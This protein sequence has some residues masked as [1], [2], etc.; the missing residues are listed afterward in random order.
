MAWVR[1][2][3]GRAVGL[4][5]VI[6]GIPLDEIG[7]TGLGVAVAAEVAAPWAGLQLEGAR[8]GVQGFGNV[9]RHASRFLAE[10]GAKLVGASDHR[11]GLCNPDGLDLDALIAHKESGRSVS[12]F[13]G[14]QPMDGVDL[15]G[16]ECDIWIPAARPDVLNEENVKR[17]KAK[18]ILQGANIPATESAERWMHEHGILSIPD[19]IANA[20]GVICASVEYRGGNTGQALE[21]IAETVRATTRETLERATADNLLPRRAA[22]EMALAR[23]REAMRY[24]RSLTHAA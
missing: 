18:L 7:A 10:R 2:E 23:V 4:P 5:R 16:I 9:G 6:G 14:G 13:R 17:L 12:D 15:V 1:D 8:V 3:T 21:T 20:G 19:F 11:G 22:K 24:R